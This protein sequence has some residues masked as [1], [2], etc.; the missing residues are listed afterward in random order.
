VT[1]AAAVVLLLGFVLHAALSGQNSIEQQIGEQVFAGSGDRCFTTVSANEEV[2]R[3]WPQALKAEIIVCETSENDSYPNY[4]LDYA[5]F[6]SA[7]ELSATLKAAPPT[8]D[9]CTIGSAVVTRDDLRNAFA[10]M[11]SNRGGS[12]HG[13]L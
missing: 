4:I 2:A 1:A 7:A 11:C 8:A 9:Y 10:V 12:L 5:R 3:H 13:G 6:S